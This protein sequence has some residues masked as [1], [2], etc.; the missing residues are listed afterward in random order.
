MRTARSWAEEPLSLR[1][2][3]GQAF[4]AVIGAGQAGRKKKAVE[5]LAVGRFDPGENAAGVFP[6]AEMVQ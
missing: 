1:Q 2:A 6:V 5:V 3:P 4:T